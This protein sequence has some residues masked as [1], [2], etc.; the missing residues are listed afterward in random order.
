MGVIGFLLGLDSRKTPVRIP[1]ELK[2]VIVVGCL[3]L[4]F[5]RLFHHD[6]DKEMDS[7]SGDAFGGHCDAGCHVALWDSFL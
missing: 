5:Q 6:P 1:V 4:H 7:Y 2:W 3:D